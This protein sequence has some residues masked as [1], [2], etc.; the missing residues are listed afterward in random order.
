MGVTYI[1]GITNLSQFNI[2]TSQFVTSGDVYVLPTDTYI[3]VNKTVGSPTNVYLP[4]SPLT[5]NP[6]VIKDGKGDASVNNI[7]VIGTVDGTVNPI[8]GA[9]Y[10]DVGIIYSGARWYQ[11]F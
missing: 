9:D 10:A 8:I 7:T 11:I 2:S 1:S 6:L 3:Y 4:S 5:N